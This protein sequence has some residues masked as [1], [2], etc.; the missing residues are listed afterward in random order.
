M[1]LA[2]P[3]NR[4]IQSLWVDSPQLAAITE[5]RDRIVKIFLASNQNV[6][7]G[8][9]FEKF[10]LIAQSEIPVKNMEALQYEKIA[11][12]A[13][14]QLASNLDPNLPEALEV[15]LARIRQEERPL[16]SEFMEVLAIAAFVV[17]VAAFVVQI[18]E[19][20]D[21]L[22]NERIRQE[23][24]Q[25]VPP[26]ESITYEQREVIIQ[27]VINVVQNPNSPVDEVTLH[28][29]SVLELQ[30]NDARAIDEI[31]QQRHAS[32]EEVPVKEIE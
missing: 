10:S 32:A 26:P 15:E 14:A 19:R 18:Q 12:Q 23:T 30:P 9:I 27:V 1:A 13:A 8:E 31:T 17:Q 3:R 7:V 29:E 5:H 25:Q 16:T 22:T 4:L 11:R 24:L 2:C 6:L 28:Q 21:R 20:Q